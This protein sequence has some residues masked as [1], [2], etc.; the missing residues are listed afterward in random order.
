M[1]LSRILIY[2]FAG[3]GLLFGVIALLV[4]L[5][6][7]HPDAFMWGMG[8]LSACGLVYPVGVLI[9]IWIHGDNQ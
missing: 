1:K 2:G 7:H 8:V 9:S 6:M 5:A 3:V 4:L